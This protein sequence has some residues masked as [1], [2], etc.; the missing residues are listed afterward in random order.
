MIFSFYP[1]AIIPSLRTRAL[2][3]SSPTAV[4]TIPASR[5][6]APSSLAVPVVL[7]GRECLCCVHFPC[8]VDD[9]G[10]F[11]DGRFSMLSGPATCSD[12]PLSCTASSAHD[13]CSGYLLDGS[14]SSTHDLRC[15][16]TVTDHRNS[17]LYQ[18]W[19][20]VIQQK[21]TST[22]PPLF[23]DVGKGSSVIY[24][25]MVLFTLAWTSYRRTSS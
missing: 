12:C 11:G 2:V 13:A 1:T 23:H 25:S 8:Y 3:S 24:V 20:T 9:G 17:D 21:C 4:D 16:L 10:P 18:P 19:F 5:S 22:T 15:V 7:L 14:P 6:I